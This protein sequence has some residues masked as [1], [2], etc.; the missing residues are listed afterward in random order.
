MSQDNVTVSIQNNNS[1]LVIEIH[2]SFDIDTASQFK[3]AYQSQKAEK[4]LI[5]MNGCS[6]ID[7]T[8]I[9]LLLTMRNYVGSEAHITIKNCQPQ[10]LKLFRLTRLETKFEILIEE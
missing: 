10:I 7:S 4:Y 8:G 5:D 6:Y 9:G 3:K 1:L 2:T